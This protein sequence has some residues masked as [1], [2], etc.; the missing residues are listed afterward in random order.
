MAARSHRLAP[1]GLAG[2]ALGAVVY[3][4]G[5][6]TPWVWAPPQWDFAPLDW[7]TLPPPVVPSTGGEEAPPTPSPVW[8]WVLAIVGVLVGLLLLVL[9]VR[10]LYRLIRALAG[11]RLEAQPD[12]DAVG[13][14]GT[15]AGRPL[16]ALEV[17]DAVTEALRRLDA[18]PTTTDAVIQAWLALEEAAGRHG[19]G[20]DPASTPTEFTVSL[21]DRSAI[22]PADTVGLKQL[23][24]RARFSD[25]PTSR[26]DVADARAWLEHIA[27]S[28]EVGA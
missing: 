22:P 7:P 11:T 3:A 1:L 25:Q 17:T 14:G 23:Y 24:L 20:R 5:H 9:L 12:A 15:A 21:L 18:A 6:P 8:G 16:S 28:L 10:W 2:V 26:A 27:G 4:S 13:A 19:L